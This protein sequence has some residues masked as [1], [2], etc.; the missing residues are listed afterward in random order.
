MKTDEENNITGAYTF[1]EITNFTN[2]VSEKNIDGVN[3]TDLFNTLNDPVNLGPI[4]NKLDD[5]DGIITE[6]EVAVSSE[7]PHACFS[8]V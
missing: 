6:L 5:T 3:V 2:I 4:T 1:E 7:C 8:F